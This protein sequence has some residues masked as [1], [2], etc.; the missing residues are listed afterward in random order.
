MTQ[1]SSSRMP[2]IRE[3]N[4]GRERR[5]GVEI[6]LSGLGYDELVTLAARLLEGT[7]VLQSRYVTKLETALGDFTVELDSDPIK[8]LDLADERL[9]Q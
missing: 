7:A 4:E 8:D 5:V 1:A 2:D 3:T 9:P 6:E